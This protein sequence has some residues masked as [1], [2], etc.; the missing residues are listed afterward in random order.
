MRFRLQL[1]IWLLVSLLFFGVFSSLSIW[2]ISRIGEKQVV[3]DNIEKANLE[4]SLQFQQL[5]TDNIERYFYHRT[6]VSGVLDRESCFY[7]ENVV[8]SGKPG[9]YVY[10]IFKPV[11]DKRY[12]LVNMGWLK[13]Q[14]D[15]TVLPDYDLQQDI[16][17]VE[18]IIQRPRS[19]P[20]VTPADGIPN[21]EHDRLWNYFDFE[22]FIEI[23][24]HDF[25]PVELQ[26]LSEV[27]TQ[28]S[29]QW[30][31]FKAKI[32]MHIGYAIHWAAFALVT[33][34]LYIRY[35]LK[36]TVKKYD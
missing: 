10:C 3:V 7:V 25:Y 1:D 29:R 2:Q 21:R 32:G 6:D 4:R 34:F 13:Q 5:S 20:V 35:L 11:H 27:D 18:G 16:T 19:K 33:A 24:G 12:L 26:L 14:G 17:R 31:Q 9:Y 30:P 28:L 23:Y 22:K 15:R 36:Q 8:R